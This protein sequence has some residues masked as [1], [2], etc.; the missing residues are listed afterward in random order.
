[1][2]MAAALVVICSVASFGQFY[3]SVLPSPLFTKALQ[4]VVWDFRFN[5]KNIKGDTIANDGAAQIYASTVSL[6]DVKGATITYYN[7]KKDTTASW[8][9][10]VYSGEHY[11][12]AVRVINK[13]H[14][15]KC[16]HYYRVY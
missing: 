7:S 9:A 5:F 12:E 1:M 13:G 3:K 2:I 4:D 8:D 11:T 14:I 16:I 10:V 6:P 15:N